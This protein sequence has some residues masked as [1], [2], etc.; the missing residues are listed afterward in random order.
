MRTFN[1]GEARQIPI[2][3]YLA[4]CGYQP[5]YIRGNNLWYLS[6][7]RQEKT[8]SFKVNANLN[9]WMDF[10]EGIGGNLIG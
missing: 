10:G 9:A 2:I 3:Q 6:P 4:K 5:Q 7:F 8:A 1:C